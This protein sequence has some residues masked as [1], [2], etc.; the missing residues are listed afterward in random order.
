MNSKTIKDIMTQEPLLEKVA[1]NIAGN[2]CANLPRDEIIASA[3]SELVD[4]VLLLVPG[5]DAGKTRVFA[6]MMVEAMLVQQIYMIKNI[7]QSLVM[8][9]FA[10]ASVPKGA[11]Q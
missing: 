7:A 5:T 6:E 8:D 1:D 9:E 11:K 4:L 10:N 3:T 2:V